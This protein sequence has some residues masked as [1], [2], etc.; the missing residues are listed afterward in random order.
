MA[1]LK[2]QRLEKD[3]SRIV[4]LFRVQRVK[5]IDAGHQFKQGAIAL[6]CNSVKKDTK[7]DFV[8]KNFNLC[9]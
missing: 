4:Y 1:S 3:M 6:L 9:T 5:K 8:T 7:L 2:L